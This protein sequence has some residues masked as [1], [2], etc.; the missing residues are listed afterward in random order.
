M[1]ESNQHLTIKKSIRIIL[2][3]LGYDVTEEYNHGR[4]RID[5]IG[6]KEDNKIAVEVGNCPAEKIPNLQ[7]KYDDA[8]H[9]PYETDDEWFKEEESEM[10]RSTVYVNSKEWEKFKDRTGENNGS[11]VLRKLIKS[12]N[13]IF[14]YSDLDA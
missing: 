7:E 11:D 3:T 6:E 12:Y 1:T 9:V 2:E 14:S 8:I 5:L 10:K 4:Y 13:K